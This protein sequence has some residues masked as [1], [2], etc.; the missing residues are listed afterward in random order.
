[1]KENRTTYRVFL[2]RK[3]STSGYYMAGYGAAMLECYMN[4]SILQLDIGPWEVGK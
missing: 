3:A 4:D 1:M 2:P